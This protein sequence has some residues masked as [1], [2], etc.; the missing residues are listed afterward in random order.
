VF[1]APSLGGAGICNYITTSAV[2]R[3]ISPHRAQVFIQFQAVLT[4]VILSAVVSLVALYL[5]KMITGLRVTPEES[6]KSGHDVPR[7]SAYKC[8]DVRP[9]RQLP[10]AR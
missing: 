8:K 5:V 9:G 3:P 1:A 2:I 10:G 7:E 4:A 6:A